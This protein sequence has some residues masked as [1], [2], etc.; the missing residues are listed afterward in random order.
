MKAINKAQKTE[1]EKMN[2]ISRRMIN[3]DLRGV[4]YDNFLFHSHPAEP[5]IRA[6]DLNKQYLF[7]IIINRNNKHE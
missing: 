3:I 2:E 7:L 6:G 4:F 1:T 5:W